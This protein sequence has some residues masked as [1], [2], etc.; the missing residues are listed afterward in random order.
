MDDPDF[1]FATEF[2]EEEG[3]KRVFIVLLCDTL[4]PL[5]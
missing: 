3:V 4:C 2:T 1:F 5:W